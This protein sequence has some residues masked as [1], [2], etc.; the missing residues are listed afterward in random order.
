M[1]DGF[2]TPFVAISIFSIEPPRAWGRGYVVDLSLRLG[3]LWHDQNSGIV[4]TSIV[5]KIDVIYYYISDATAV[6][7]QFL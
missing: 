2:R 3:I 1:L 7:Q 5:R 4:K 6:S